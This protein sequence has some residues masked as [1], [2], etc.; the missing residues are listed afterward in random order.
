MYLIIVLITYRLLVLYRI[1]ESRRCFRCFPVI[2]TLEKFFDTFCCFLQIEEK[3]NY[4]DY[5]NGTDMYIVIAS[6]KFSSRQI[7][8]YNNK[9]FYSNYK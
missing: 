1:L 6:N 2:V 3:H 8:M 5:A 4:M 9:L 7:T